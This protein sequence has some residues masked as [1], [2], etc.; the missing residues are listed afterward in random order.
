MTPEEETMPA[1]HNPKKKRLRISASNGH[2]L[3]TR[4]SGKGVPM[5]TP[6]PSRWPLSIGKA[7]ALPILPGTR[8][9]QRTNEK[10]RLATIDDAGPSPGQP[11]QNGFRLS[12]ASRYR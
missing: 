12:V 8:H 2:L 5:A 4:L 1:A 3:R 11:I 9:S 10:I 7:D 6:R